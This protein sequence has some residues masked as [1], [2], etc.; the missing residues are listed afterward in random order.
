M[1]I[2]I[3]VI[4]RSKSNSIEKD[5]DGN[6]KVKLNAPPVEGKANAALIKFLAEYFKIKKSQI[7]IIGGEKSRNKI[8]EI[9]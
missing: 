5:G 2:N 9:C 6:Y 1:L 4:P 7:K 8:V 3:K